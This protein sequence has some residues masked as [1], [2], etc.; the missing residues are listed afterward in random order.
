MVPSITGAIAGALL[1]RI[2]PAELFDRLVP[3]LILFA[4]V[5]FAVQERVQQAAGS[6]QP[7]AASVSSPL[8]AARFR[9]F[10][11]A[12]IFQFLV[13]VDVGEFGAGLRI[14]RL[15][16]SASLCDPDLCHR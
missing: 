6:G 5:L 16:A 13:S 10:A 8:P 4:T 15:S 7:A 9:W 1:L 14:L 3:L 12:M 2:T 11:G